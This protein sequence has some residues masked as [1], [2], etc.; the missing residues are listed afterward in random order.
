MRL[1]ILASVVLVFTSSLIAA[2]ELPSEATVDFNKCEP[3]LGRV[4]V[5]LGEVFFEV[6]GKSRKGCV[7]L[8]GAKLEDPRR[9]DPFPN[10]IC[11]VPFVVG[12]RALPIREMGFDDSTLGQNCWDLKRP[13]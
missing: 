12:V 10:R 6:V 2:A 4:T 8:T 3:S 13:G 7:M 5:P 9:M 1:Y 11:I